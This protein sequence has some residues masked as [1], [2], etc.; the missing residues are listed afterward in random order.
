MGWHHGKD[1]IEVNTKSDSK[2]H[3][4]ERPEGPEHAVELRLKGASPEGRNGIRDKGV[5]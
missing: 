5:G 1:F 3:E 4:N 2:P